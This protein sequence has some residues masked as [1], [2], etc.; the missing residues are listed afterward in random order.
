MMRR[1]LLILA[2]VLLAGAVSVPATAGSASNRIGVEVDGRVL[3]AVAYAIEGRTMV[4]M[5]AIFERLQAEVDWDAS[6]RTVTAV[7]GSTTVKLT[8][9]TSAAR[10][11]G[12]N[13]KLEV[14]PMDIQGRTFVPLRFVSEALGA[15][16]GYDGKRQVVSVRTIGGTGGVKPDASNPNTGTA[17]DAPVQSKPAAAEAYVVQGRATDRLGQPMEGVEIIADNQLARDSYLTAYTD[18]DGYYRID[19]PELNTTY[20]MISYYER[21][22]EGNVHAFNLTSVVDRPFGANKGAVRD[23]VWEDIHG[24]VIIDIDDY[25]DDEN[26]PEFSLDEVELTLTPVSRLIDGSEGEVIQAMSRFSPDGPG[27]DEVPIAKY[28][29][30]ARW[31]PR[32]MEP[33]P[34]LVSAWG[35]NRYAESV[36]TA[37]W[38]DIYGTT[39]RVAIKVA[40][41]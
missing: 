35:E 18:E 21:K 30:T 39:K 15:E 24:K 10:V 5:R 41:P 36:T 31:A 8:Y 26:L 13:V 14:P 40:I 33:M 19:L 29:I 23:F 2:A 6:T 28:A 34:L 17:T 3:D 22:F 1:M 4:P 25:P 37:D 16:V 32:G 7:K 11:N 9:G 12:M 38:D 27:L 20:N